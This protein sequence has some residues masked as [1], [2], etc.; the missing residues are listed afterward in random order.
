MHQQILDHADCAAL[1]AQAKFPDLCE[2]ANARHAREKAL[3]GNRAPMVILRA[4]HIYPPSNGAGGFGFVVFA[5]AGTR[6]HETEGYE[7]V[8][9]AFAPEEFR[10]ACGV[11]A[12]AS[13]VYDE[14][15]IKD[16]LAEQFRAGSNQSNPDVLP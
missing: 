14:T 7:G 16:D 5:F 10:E 1:M 6:S 2:A 4:F 13:A 8:E 12:E 11:L 9:V 3:L 15:F